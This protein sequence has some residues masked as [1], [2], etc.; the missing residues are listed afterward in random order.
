MVGTREA[1][2]RL[3][4]GT[5]TFMFT[6][7]EGSTRLLREL[8]ADGYERALA[9]H[10]RL[11]RQAFAKHGGVEVDTQGDAF[12]VAFA[13][14]V[15]AI[16]SA[17]E[18]QQVLEAGRIRVRMGL[19]TGR[20]RLSDEGYVGED[21]HIGARMAAAGHG[22]QVL[23][24]KTTAEALSGVELTDLGEH[25]L[26]DFPESVWIYQLGSERFAPLKTISNTN[27][28]RPAS[29]FVGRE[30]E[31]SEITALLRDG[32][33]MVTL[34]GPGG[35]GKTRLSI[36]AA[37]ELVP[38]FKNGTFWVDLAPLRDHTL[39]SETVARTLGAKDGLADHI[40]EREML[41]LI[42]NLEQVVAAAPELA[43]LVESCPSLRVLTTSRELLRV[44]GEV[45]YPV[46]PLADP[47]AVEL[48]SARSRLPAD[49]TIEELCRRLE[50]LP[51]A[52]E[53]A[54]ARASV[55]TPRQIL[56]RLSGRLDLLKGGRDADPR[57]QTLRAAIEW[58]YDLLDS[59]ER[60][61]FSRLAVFAGGATLEA[62]ER[63]VDAELD[64]LQALVDKSLLRHTGDRF[65]MLETI[66]EFAA[67]RLAASGVADKLGQRH[68][69]HFLEV[70]ESLEKSMFGPGS[71]EVNDAI[72][73][74]HANFRA[75]LEHFEATGDIE[76]A[77]R[78][79]GALTV[80]WD[81]RAHHTEAL[82]RYVALLSAADNAP[83]ETRAKVLDGAA[84][85]ALMTGDAT[86]AWRWQMEALEIN[87][88]LGN[89]PGIA[90]A[91]WGLGYM[92]TEQG[93]YDDAGEFL[94]EAVQLLQ[95][96][97]DNVSLMW[98]TRTLAHNYLERGDLQRARLRYEESLERAR[99][100]GDRTLEAHDTGALGSIAIRQ[101]RRGEAA[102]LARESL[103]LIVDVK[104]P[105]AV[106]AGLTSAAVV[107]MKLGQTEVASQLLGHADV[108][109]MEVGAQEP[110]VAKM[111]Q[112][113][114]EALRERLEDSAFD[115]AW[116]RGR[117]L[118]PD[119]A[120]ALATK[121]LDE[122]IEDRL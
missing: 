51:L 43:T 109:Q 90:L 44:R 83:T 34:T 49:A 17:R 114:I 115:D 46:P 88:E 25:R 23:L 82:S 7:I 40:G 42:D 30:R 47:E 19:H 119:A 50:N 99:A 78:L 28:P 92:S 80:F 91:L 73:R 66:H 2:R 106:L 79:A 76:Y 6:D 74:D 61:L 36:E 39:V 101:G 22:G 95:E 55:L 20:P 5:V 18:A 63:V 56:D 75:A 111:K 122:A 38:D 62:A 103:Q 1:R 116:E 70:A 89:K 64:T 48:F 84:N 41:L 105:T 21:V 107:L 102:V 9:E 113:A 100:A 24:S 32:A 13:D 110:W 117:A 87:R 69:E 15:A 26:K 72:E 68:A 118:S 60:E 65:W 16:S 35:T 120:R 29:S 53:L 4:T 81:Q 33:R 10:R 98:I 12:F 121:A 37:A 108:R 52:V 85:M 104:D 3:P 67:E 93:R 31:V 54:A 94:N 59:G 97:N 57:Q 14:A 45:E 86:A 11:L 112:E 71:D 27:L 58:S 77:M 96:L 8:G